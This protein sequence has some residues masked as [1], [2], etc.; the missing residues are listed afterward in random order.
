[1]HKDPGLLGVGVAVVVVVLVVAVVVLLVE[2]VVL[3][4]VDNVLVV[5]VVLVVEVVL[6]V[7][8]GRTSTVWKTVVVVVNMGVGTVVVVY[9]MLVD[10]VSMVFQQ[11]LTIM[12]H[13][14]QEEQPVTKLAAEVH[15]FTAHAGMT[16]GEIVSWRAIRALSRFPTGPTTVI[17]DVMVTVEVL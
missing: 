17:L 15:P 5:D 6:V 12:A 9:E 11:S 7:W 2:D 10:A 16:L 13:P 1:L 14:A 8:G 3:V 4:V